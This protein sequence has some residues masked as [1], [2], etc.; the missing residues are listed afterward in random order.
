[1]FRTLSDSQR[2]I[3]FNKS[4]KFVVRACPGSGKTYCVGA[5]LARLIHDWKKRHE[6]IA[7]LS[8]TNVAWQE[9]EKKCNE[10]FSISKI[11]YPHFLGTID[12]FVNK[13][14][15]LPFGHLILG[16]K[17]RPIL[18]GEP[19]GTWSGKD[20]SS[21]LFDNISYAIDG[22]MYAIQAT[23][24]N[25]NWQQ[26][27]YITGAKKRY[28]KA[29]YATQNDANFFAMK[30]LEKYPQIAKA[31]AVRFPYLIVD[32]AQDTS[33]IQMKIIDILIENGLS[34]IM[35]VGDP[36]QAIFEWNDA[37]PELLTQKYDEWENSIILNENRRS[38]QNICG[39]TFG[40]SSLSDASVSVNEQVREFAHRPKVITYNSNLPQIVSD[41]IDECQQQ[42]INVSKESTAIIY[43]SKSIVNEI[44]GIPEITFG[45]NVWVDSHTREF[46]RGKFLYDNGRFK[47]GFKIL[48]RI[49]LKTLSN[50]SYCS[51][52]DI[53]DAIAQMGFVTF[54]SQIHAFINLLPRTNISIGEWV[55]AANKA[56]KEN[57]CGF[58]LRVHKDGLRLSFPQLFLNEDKQIIEKN[59]RYGT[60]HSVKGETFEAVLLILKTKGIGSAYKTLLNKNISI[61]ASEELRIAYVGMT[62]PSKIL[63]IAVPNDDNKNAWENKLVRN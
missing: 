29:G 33:D 45:T 5:R 19:H 16:C 24:M 1:M 25:A 14:I 8:F 6:G 54:K 26:N 28:N 49:L 59:Y 47:D 22:S 46:A 17:G 42:G 60:V 4:G 9:I 20:F 56:L 44:L 43:R 51:E 31:I 36:D 15:F 48:E 40:I 10:K 58:E 32:E 23:K 18:V 55:D 2:E 13:Y 35:L 27:K 52:D 12:S 63:V 38:S 57:N 41:F 37:R 21:T 30:I 61:S 11:A 7:V 39:F 53:N 50:L 3:V 34:E 62:R